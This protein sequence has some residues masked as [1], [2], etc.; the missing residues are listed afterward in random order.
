[1]NMISSEKAYANTKCK[2]KIQNIADRLDMLVEKPNFKE[3][4]RKVEDILDEAGEI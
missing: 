3:I 1:M 4:I 2:N